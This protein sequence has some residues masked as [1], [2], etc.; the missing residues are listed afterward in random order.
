[1]VPRDHPTTPNYALI[2]SRNVVRHFWPV[3]QDDGGSTAIVH[4]GLEFVR[5]A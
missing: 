3:E 4:I 5:G 1:M 2:Q